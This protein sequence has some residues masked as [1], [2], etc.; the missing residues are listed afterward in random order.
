MIPLQELKLPGGHQRLFYL[1]KIIRLHT[2]F[3]IFSVPAIMEKFKYFN[4]K[5][6]DEII[7]NDKA[8]AESVIEDNNKIT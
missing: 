4:K 8:L 3:K 7:A 6:I 5:K 1:I 2:G